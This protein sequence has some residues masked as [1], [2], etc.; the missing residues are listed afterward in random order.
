MKVTTSDRPILR[1]T[2]LGKQVGSPPRELFRDLSVTVDRGELVAV[3][4]R[5]GCGKSTLLNIVGGLDGAYLG[6]VE[7]DGVALRDLG[8]DER[9]GLRLHQVGMVFQAY[10]LVDH[11]SLL[12]NVLLPARFA[13]AA[14]R[15]EAARRAPDLLAAVGLSH[16][17]QETPGP[18]S[19][20]ERQRVAIAR[21]LVMQPALLLADEPTGNLDRATAQG[22][23]SVFRDLAARAGSAVLLVTHDP[24]V[25]SVAHRTVWLR[26]HTLHDDATPPRGVNVEA[27]P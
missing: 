23:L 17:A 24:S 11:L 21:A 1:V 12:A 27:A 26:E 20:G 6:R 18:L 10:Y 9:S 3:C 8:D 14:A 13:D 22:V 7:L 19:G 2:G 4:G 5:S 15:R 25:A 16:R